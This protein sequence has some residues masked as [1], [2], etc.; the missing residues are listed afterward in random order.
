MLLWRHY[1]HHIAMEKYISLGVVVALLIS[2]VFAS[3]QTVSSLQAQLQS[4]EAE[5]AALQA[6]GTAS[7]SGSTNT[8]N[9]Q[10]CVNLTFAG[11]VG[12]SG[13]QVS[14]LQ[15]YLGIN[16]ATG[17]FG[18]KTK[19]ALAAW[20]SSHAISATGYFGSL[21]RAAMACGNGAATVNS[22]SVP[23][24]NSSGQTQT[25]TNAQYGFALQYP[26]NFSATP[27]SVLNGTKI[28]LTGPQLS[29][30][31]QAP[32][33]LIEASNDP[34]AVSTCNTASLSGLATVALAPLTSLGVNITPTTGTQTIGGVS[35]RSASVSADLEGTFIQVGFYAAL[36]NGVCYIIGTSVEGNDPSTQ[37]QLQ[38]TSSVV[39]PASAASVAGEENTILQSLTFSTPTASVSQSGVS[40]ALSQATT[41]LQDAVR[42]SD[43][44]ADQV[45]LELYYSQNGKYPSALIAMQNVITS[46]QDFYD[47]A[48]FQ[49]YNYQT[50]A[51]GDSYT[52]CATL[53][54]SSPYCVSNAGQTSSQS[55][56]NVNAP[57]CS[58]TFTPSVVNVGQGYTYSWNSTNA[59]SFQ[60]GVSGSM[61]E[62][63][64]P[65]GWPE[66][67]SLNGNTSAAS[68]SPGTF[69]YSGTVSGPGGTNSCSSTLTVQPSGSSATSPSTSSS[70]PYPISL[71]PS[72]GTVGTQV[73][74]TGTGFATTGGNTVLFDG[75]SLGSQNATN[76]TLNFTVP[77]IIYPSCTNSSCAGTVII[78]GSH[79]ITV[80]NASG[81]S[82]GLKILFT[83][84][85]S[86]GASAAITPQNLTT[87][88][89]YPV[90]LQGTAS[91]ATQVIVDL[92]T[93]QSGTVWNS[94]PITVTN[95]QWSVTTSSLQ[96]GTYTV[97]VV[98][99]GGNG[100]ALATGTLTAQ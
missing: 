41:A 43:L 27:A 7:A 13:T 28:T 14:S 25:Y 75:V 44:N 58:I 11:G 46:T 38:S 19:A 82:S 93:P 51:A 81:Q 8:S 66:N 48:T 90:V 74:I 22:A 68:A 49:P 21:T 97:S 42:K 63:P 88:S 36:Q 86:G 77:S 6:Q 100:T 2:P 78:P 91:G 59:T 98:Q 96:P 52:L 70:V 99:A 64:S 50:D 83:V 79:Y 69:T 65:A 20:Q 89:G 94:G 35:F 31:S 60:I 37:G 72:Q 87:L 47:P 34:S 40:S 17:Y 95:G 30:F 85:S 3:A 76:G 39:L 57:T 53:S 92:S 62:K 9:S 61:I 32:S 24:S 15:A 10:A 55:N 5:I 16:P 80:Q 29:G 4:L 54:S 56:A 26:S 1:R 23:N 45:D 71:S 33:V 84:L 18:T 67:P 73:I 12:T